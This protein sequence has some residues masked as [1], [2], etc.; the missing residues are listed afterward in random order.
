MGIATLCLHDPPE[1]DEDEG[2]TDRINGDA[3]EECHLLAAL[4]FLYFAVNLLTLP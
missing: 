3:N 1:M 4:S 2:F